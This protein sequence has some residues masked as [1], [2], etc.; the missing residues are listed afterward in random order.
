M[1]H[2]VRPLVKRD[3]INADDQRFED[4]LLVFSRGSID[5]EKL[6]T[7]LWTGASF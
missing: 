1:V 5:S 6:S 7:P 2:G 4:I 3:N